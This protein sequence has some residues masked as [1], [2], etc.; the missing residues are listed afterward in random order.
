MHPLFHNPRK[1]RH[2]GNSHLPKRQHHFRGTLPH[3]PARTGHYQ[4]RH[5]MKLMKKITIGSIN[6]VRGGFKAMT[7]FGLRTDP[8]NKDALLADRESVPVMTVIGI[9]HSYTE[10]TSEDM[11]TSYAFNGEFQAINKD[12]E[13]CMGPVLYLPEPA[14]GLAKSALDSASSIDIGFTFNA[15]RSDD[16]LK[17]YEFECIPLQEPAPS[18]ALEAL[19]ARLLAG[20]AVRDAAVVAEPGLDPTRAADVGKVAKA[21]K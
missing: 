11:G 21:K 20:P 14:Q 9:A 18:G 8:N 1:V 10:K 16:A 3:N 6:N 7:L 5:T 19:S 12:G 4:R 2:S 17:G 15:L 13:K